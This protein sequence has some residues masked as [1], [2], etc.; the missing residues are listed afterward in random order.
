MKKI[1]A[2][3]AEISE[4]EQ[5][6]K[7]LEHRN[8]SLRSKKKELNEELEGVRTQV[9]ASHRDCRRLLKEQEVKREEE[10]AL[11]GNRYKLAKM[12]TLVRA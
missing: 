7:E 10:V 1:E 6:V 4:M 11:T 2:L 9:E 8:H 3:H 12:D 5:Q